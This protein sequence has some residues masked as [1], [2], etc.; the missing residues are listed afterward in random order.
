MGTLATI[1]DESPLRMAEQT[2]SQ[3]KG[4]LHWIGVRKSNCAC[5]PHVEQLQGLRAH[6]PVTKASESRSQ[7]L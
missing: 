3:S 5:R 6:G 1:D 4:E 2:S 7:P